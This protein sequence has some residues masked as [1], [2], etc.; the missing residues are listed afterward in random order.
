M[1]VYSVA[2]NPPIG[3]FNVA[4]ISFFF[5]A[6]VTNLTLSRGRNNLVQR[7]WQHESLLRNRGSRC[8]H[9]PI[10]CRLGRR[11]KSLFLLQ[12]SK[13][14]AASA[15]EEYQ[16]ATNQNVTV[17]SQQTPNF[18]RVFE[19]QDDKGGRSVVEDEDGCCGAHDVVDAFR[20]CGRG[21]RWRRGRGEKQRSDAGPHQTGGGS[22]ET[23]H[24]ESK[25]V[26]AC[27]PVLCKLLRT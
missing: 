23:A 25:V 13:E 11:Q 26:S 22:D 3:S 2:E 9:I 5:L 21:V 7:R 6:N 16:R 17:P 24:E 1:R 4:Y 12:P 18:H 10:C 8:A 20:K 19:C 14:S 15:V 27:D